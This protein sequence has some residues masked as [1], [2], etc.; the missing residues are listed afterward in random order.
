MDI[1]IVQG[2]DWQNVNF[3]HPRDLSAGIAKGQIRSNYLDKFGVLY[4]EFVFLPLTFGLVTTAS[5][6]I[7]VGRTIIA[8]R[9]SAAKTAKVPHTTNKLWF[10]D[11]F[12]Q[13][14]AE[15]IEI[16]RGMVAV[17]P[18]VTELN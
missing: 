15:T 10:Y 17:V 2:A 9:I 7:P 1:T 13:L 4:A 18:R 14:G 16:G 3:Y 12:V 5:S 8:P 11:I 6:N